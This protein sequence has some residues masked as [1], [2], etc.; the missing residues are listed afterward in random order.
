MSILW[1]KSSAWRWLVRKTRDSKPFFFGF[2]TVCAV[3]PGVVG[4]YV[5]QITNSR[6]DQLE[7]QLRRDA[8]PDTLL[9]GKVNK[10]R[11]GEFLGELQRKEDTNDRY[12]AALKGETLTR[13]PYIRIQPVNPPQADK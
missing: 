6:N 12:V 3:V 10:E 13:N 5:M 8:R 2:A 9:M 11:L 1:E 7:A 4:Y